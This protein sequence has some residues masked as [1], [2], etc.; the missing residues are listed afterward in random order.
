LPHRIRTVL[1]NKP[2]IIV[3]VT[4]DLNTDQRVHRTCLQL[5]H[6][7]FEVLLAG[8]ELP[9]SAPMDQRSYQTVRFRLLFTKGALFYATFNIRLFIFLMFSNAKALLANDLDT[10]PANYLT[11]R[12]R[13]IPLVYDSHEYYTGVPEL[14]HRPLVRGIWKRIEQYIFPRLKTT[15]T[16]NRSIARLYFQEYGTEPV[17]IRNVPLMPT[18]PDPPPARESLGLPA[19]KKIVVLQGAGI[20]IDRGS[21]EAVAAMQYLEG[22]VLLIIGGGDVLPILQKL[23]TNLNLKEKVIFKPRMPYAEMM[24]HT[25]VCDLGLTL[26]KDSNINYRFSLPNKIFDYIHAGLPVLA[27]RLPEVEAVVKGYDVGDF[28]NS[29]DPSHIAERIRFMLHDQE[30]IIRWKKNLQLASRELNWEKESE[31]FPDI[32]HELSR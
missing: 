25:M 30:S 2:L 9:A 13:R 7:G 8:R 10:L 24:K 26:D 14:E 32:I 15:I 28:I 11:S 1:S 4:S 21:E 3:S 22:V 18:L 12:L 19:H 17:V 20:N 5:Q 27:S 23:T 16:V 29:H 6:Q 31:K